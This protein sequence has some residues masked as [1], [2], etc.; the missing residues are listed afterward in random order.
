MTKIST[1]SLIFLLVLYVILSFGLSYYYD[2][3]HLAN[4]MGASLSAIGA[5]MIILQV[6]REVRF[7]AFN[8]GD[9]AAAKGPVCLFGSIANREYPDSAGDRT[10]SS[11]DANYC[12]YRNHGICRR[13]LARMG[14]FHIRQNSWWRSSAVGRTA[15]RTARQISAPSFA[16]FASARCGPARSTK[17]PDENP[18]VARQFSISRAIYARSTCN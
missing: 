11:K 4:R 2:D 9:E 13:S 12:I 3:P 18:T 5:L 14:R 17:M 16:T 6:Q 15:I 1:V 8:K 7:E 10:A